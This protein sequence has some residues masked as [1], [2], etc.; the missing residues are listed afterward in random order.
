MKNINH[1]LYKLPEVFFINGDFNVELFKDIFEQTG[2]AS[3]FLKQLVKNIQRESPKTIEE[4]IIIVCKN[5]PNSAFRADWYELIENK[6]SKKM[7]W[8]Y[9]YQLTNSWVLSAISN[10][11]LPDMKLIDSE[12]KKLLFE[13]SPGGA[14]YLRPT[15]IP[16]VMEEAFISDVDP[17]YVALYLWSFSEAAMW[18]EYKPGQFDYETCVFPTADKMDLSEYVNKVCEYLKPNLNVG[19]ISKKNKSTTLVKP[20]NSNKIN[21]EKE[22]SLLPKKE[23]T[24]SKIK[25]KLKQLLDEINCNW[26]DYESKLEKVSSY[27][28]D[29]KEDTSSEIK[30]TR[31]YE[32][33]SVVKDKLSEIHDSIN[34][35]SLLHRELFLKM[36]KNI[37]GREE[38]VGGRHN[39][40][41]VNVGDWI[42]LHLDKLNEIDSHHKELIKY[43]DYSKKLKK[44]GIEERWKGPF[45]DCSELISWIKSSNREMEKI[46]FE[47][48]SIQKFRERCAIFALD[49]KWDPL[50]DK[51]LDMDGWRTLCSSLQKKSINPYAVGLVLR[52]LMEADYE[53]IKSIIEGSIGVRSQDL[54]RNCKILSM[55]SNMQ[56]DLLWS[57]CTDLRP[58]LTMCSLNSWFISSKNNDVSATDYWYQKSLK[59]TSIHLD[60]AHIHIDKTVSNFLYDLKLLD[61]KVAN[62]SGGALQQIISRFGEDTAE[63][64]NRINRL[65]EQVKQQLLI[66]PKFRG[67]YGRLTN[68]AYE[69]ILSPFH[70]AIKARNPVLV[71]DKYGAFREGF[72]FGDWYT[73]KTAGFEKRYISSQHKKKVQ[74]YLDERF[75]CLERWLDAELSDSQ[76]LNK[77]LLSMQ[78][79]VKELLEKYDKKSSLS[80]VDYLSLLGWWLSKLKNKTIPP[81]SSAVNPSGSLVSSSVTANLID[82]C[83]FP[84]RCI[85]EMAKGNVPTWGDYFADVLSVWA[86]PDIVSTILN[87]WKDDD[88]IQC[89][90]LYLVHIKEI[91]LDYNELNLWVNNREKEI[92]R[93]FLFEIKKITS[94]VDVINNDLKDLYISELDDLNEIFDAKDWYALN[95][96]IDGLKKE[97]DTALVSYGNEEKRKQ[98]LDDISFL[99]G[100]FSNDCPLVDLEVRFEELMNAASER[101]VHIDVLQELLGLPE[102]PE[103]VFNDIRNLINILRQP[104]NLPDKERSQW[105]RCIFEELFN[106][107]TT[108]LKMP[109]FLKQEYL[110]ILLNLLTG[111]MQL[112]TNTEWIKNSESITEKLL[113]KLTELLRKEGVSNVDSYKKIL[114]LLLSQTGGVSP[115]YVGW[116]S[117]EIDHQA[118]KGDD[119]LAVDSIRDEA[120]LHKSR[121]LIKAAVIK[122][123]NYIENDLINDDFDDEKIENLLNQENWKKVLLLC[124][125]K[126]RT[127]KDDVLSDKWLLSAGFSVL[128]IPDYSHN[129]EEV[130]AILFI[131][132]YNKSGKI[133]DIFYKKAKGDDKNYLSTI[134]VSWLFDCDIDNVSSCRLDEEKTGLSA[135][136]LARVIG[137]NSNNVSAVIASPILDSLWGFASGESNWGAEFRSYLLN[138]CVRGGMLNCLVYLLK[139]DPIKMKDQRAKLFS[140]LI[141]RATDT[142]GWERMANFIETEQ[143]KIRSKPFVLFSGLLLGAN[144][145]RDEHPAEINVIGLAEK[146]KEKNLWV[147]V[148]EVNPSKLDPPQDIILQLSKNSPI[149]FGT[150]KNTFYRITGPFLDRKQIRIDLYIKQSIRGKINIEVQCRV[151]TLQDDRFEYSQTLLIDTVECDD[152]FVPPTPEFIN[153]CFGGFSNRPMRG[154]DFI[155]RDMDEKTIEELLFDSSNAGSVWITSPRRSGKTSML[156]RILDG[157]SYKKGRDDIVLYFT[158]DKQFDSGEAFNSWILRRTIKDKDNKKLHDYIPNLKEIGAGLDKSDDVDIFIPELA[159]KLLK[160]FPPGAR[161]YFVLDEVD[162]MA[163]MFLAGGEKKRISK[164]IMWQLRNLT[165][166]EDNVGVVFAGSHAARRIFIEDPNEAFYNSISKLDLAPF[167][168]DTDINLLRTRDILY[169][170]SLSNI[171]TVSKDTM[172]HMLFITAGIPYYMKLL[173]GATFS[174]AKHSQ[175]FIADVNEGAIRMLTKETGIRKIDMLENPGEDEL[176]TL[177]AKSVDDK[178]LIMGVLLAV[179]DIRSPISGQPVKVGEIWSERSPLVLQAGLKR[180]D[181]EP[182]LTNAKDLGFLKTVPSSEYQVV[183]S[184]PLL[185]ESMRRRFSTCWADIEQNLENIGRI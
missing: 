116:N 117:T 79:S 108:L 112:L 96:G 75:D 13:V 78:S 126:I 29:L 132:E 41:V 32:F 47:I 60:E 14:C 105:I 33:I 163:E 140:S 144:K 152:S 178:T 114:E 6:K 141:E 71:N 167:N 46:V 68:N 129:I 162:K 150:E 95:I 171:F 130:E 25:S 35:Y 145:P 89:L 164:T 49:K 159:E 146:R 48:D 137:S 177:Y 31:L 109:G 88:R 44:F 151:K 69:E 143:N 26:N 64:R 101:L 90:R 45:S 4:R 104:K 100:K 119:F 39:V 51:E 134:I 181:I 110:E 27:C 139:K 142:P 175:I 12:R 76:L 185:G 111:L 77:E 138:M 43:S 148:F 11:G 17:K 93:T 22:I 58:I 38:L 113:I 52:K 40:D 170:K 74:Q 149:L 80:F 120:A 18:R 30:I 9:F 133:P 36:G 107:L 21:K 63:T 106:P 102:L 2:H 73:R 161:V 3:A 172:E 182:A 56:I 82:E 37:I 50:A 176:S 70:D 54:G 155:P 160:N 81:V 55:L 173:A 67:N 122:C 59:D 179:A 86:C 7:H 154:E 184:I 10:Q 92:S 57:S 166:R 127:N 128:Y 180:E 62:F 65:Y 174:A 61:T 19:I 158:M 121:D 168:V 83:L 34:E 23:T 136:A 87:Q 15:S 85:S 20:K 125:S 98:L 8:D 53:Q 1:N 16:V 94:K 123:S 28:T 147:V 97:V 24:S 156:F 5:M 66:M 103:S 84:W 72:E 131:I 157:F 153:K 99:G 135:I 124:A 42:G 165:L 169:P 118:T 183:F 115:N 91:S